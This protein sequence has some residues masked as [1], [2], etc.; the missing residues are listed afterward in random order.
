MLIGR[1]ITGTLD[2]DTARWVA[3]LADDAHAKLAAIGL[4]AKRGCAQL[5]PWVDAYLDGRADLKPTT[6]KLYRKVRRYLL[7]HL[8]ADR[9]MR[10]ITRDEASRWHEAL[11]VRG[12]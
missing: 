12:R 4:I 1:R 10:A 6:L 3:G 7:E 11:A 5:G 9:D 8:G 2:D